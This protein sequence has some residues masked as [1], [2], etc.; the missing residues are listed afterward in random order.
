V[1]ATCN[2][3]HILIRARA[4]VSKYFEAR[5]G[6]VEKVRDNAEPEIETRSHGLGDGREPVRIIATEI[7][8]SLENVN[9]I[10]FHRAV[11]IIR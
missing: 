5:L 1:S 9:P 7:V 6:G 8:S 4:V 10:F 11:P 2:L 3:H